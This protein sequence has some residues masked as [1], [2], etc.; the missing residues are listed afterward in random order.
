M[1]FVNALDISWKTSIK[2]ESTNLIM[3]SICDHHL[4]KK[5]R[6]VLLIQWTVNISCKS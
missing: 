5:A 1:H 2:K 6:S 4:I 3:L